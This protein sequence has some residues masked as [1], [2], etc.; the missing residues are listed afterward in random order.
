MAQTLYNGIVT[1]TNSDAYNLT[2][3]LVTMGQSGI[4][5]IPVAS[6]SARNALAAAAPGGTLPVGT[7]VIRK[8]QSMFLETWDG[9]TWKAGGHVEW[10][11]SAQVV[12]NITV[13]GVGAL[14]Q[15]STKTND[16][17]FI[18]HPASDQLKFRD[19]GTY[20]ITFTAKASAAPTGRSFV[21]LQAAGDPVIRTVM[22]G[23]DRG[24]ATIPNYRA[25]ANEILTFDVYQTSGGN[26]TYDFR[27][28]VTRV[29]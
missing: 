3:D 13:W 21:E 5:P 11:R 15:D 19:A 27:I 12:P 9:S 26:L 17:A 23:E 29:A 1:P 16:T 10:T 22:T 18:T 6:V 4:T 7:M 24:A 20:S 25:A 8:D 14:T 28:R 2:A